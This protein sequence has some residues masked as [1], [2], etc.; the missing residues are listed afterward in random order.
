MKLTKEE[1][2]TLEL[3]LVDAIK[4]SDVIF[5]EKVLHDDL[6]FLA[7][8][9]QVVTKQL[10]LASHKRGEMTVNTLIPKI[11]EINIIDDTAV[12][13]TVY[14]TSG[15]ML[16]S[17]IRGEFRYVRIWKLFPVGLKVIGGGCMKL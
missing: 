4:T 7:P 1:I 15:T 16:G 9:G 17:P 2:T 10:D 13:V 5:I 12:S 8:N 3:A 14:Q 6:L 11:E